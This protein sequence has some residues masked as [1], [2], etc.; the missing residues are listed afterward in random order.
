MD[1]KPQ[2]TEKSNTGA[3]IWMILAVLYAVSPIDIISDFIPFAGW[4]DDA[5]AL[6]TGGLNLLQV[7]VGKGNEALAAILKLVKWIVF[8]LGLLITLILFL[9]GVLVYKVV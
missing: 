2:K 7:T 6:I 9:I 1:N 3:Y 4:A 5:L 8:G